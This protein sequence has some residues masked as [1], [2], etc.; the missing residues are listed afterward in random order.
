VEWKIDEAMKA[1]YPHYM[2]KEIHEQQNTIALE[3]HGREEEIEA[4]RLPGG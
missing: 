3:L 4:I 1:G 2:L